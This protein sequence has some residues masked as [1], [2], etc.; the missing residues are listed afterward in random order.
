MPI[1]EWTCVA[2]RKRWGIQLTVE[3]YEQAL[4]EGRVG[5]CPTCHRP[6]GRFYG[7][8]QFATVTHEMQVTG[9]G[10]VSDK[11]QMGEMLQKQQDH[12]SERHGRDIKLGL[13][14]PDPAKFGV[15]EE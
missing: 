4:D 8:V 9:L 1:Y 15:T 3:Q 12:L 2:C 11:R 6:G 10:K 13:A 7:D 14:D 5:M